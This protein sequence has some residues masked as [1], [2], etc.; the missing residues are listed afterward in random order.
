MGTYRMYTGDD[1]Q[2]HVETI[3]LAQTPEWTEAQAATTISFREAPVGAVPGLAPGAPRPVRHHPVR[4]VGN[5]LWGRLQA[6]IRPRRRPPGS[7]HHRP[8]P[9]HRH[10]RRRALRHRHRAFGRVTKR[11]V[12]RR[13]SV[14]AGC[15]PAP[16]Q[17]IH[18]FCLV[19]E[20]TRPST[21][22]G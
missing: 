19:H 20:E 12:F 6:G 14:G 16:F 7:R 4:P 1:G 13:I 22:S 18:H 8:G 10:L 2:T 15:Q 3:D 9:H 11:Q 5:W 21:G 17:L